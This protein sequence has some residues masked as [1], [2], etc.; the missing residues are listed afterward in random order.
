MGATDLVDE[1]LTSDD[2]KRQQELKKQIEA[3]VR[4]K[5]NEV[6]KYISPGITVNFGIAAVPDAVYQLSSG[7][8]AELFTQNVILLGYSSVVPYLLL[9]F[10][11]TLK[12]S[13]DIDFHKLDESVHSAKGSIS[14]IQKELDGRFSKAMTE[15]NNSKRDM[16]TTINKINTSLSLLEL[17]AS[18][19]IETSKEK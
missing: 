17:M 9:V 16:T 15:L 3:K 2:P 14:E 1:F 10:Q 7:I 8:L 18:K 4:A 12:S 6:K 11:T 13:C 5:A 19:Q